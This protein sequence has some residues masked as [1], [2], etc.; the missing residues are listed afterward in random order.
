MSSTWSRRRWTFEWLTRFSPMRT[1]TVNS[2][3][4]SGQNYVYNVEIT[5]CTIG[6]TVAGTTVRTCHAAV[7]R[8]ACRVADTIT[9]HYNKYVSETRV[10]DNLNANQTYCRVV[11]V[12][13]V[14]QSYGSS[15]QATT[16]MGAQER[17]EPKKA[18]KNTK[19]SCRLMKVSA[20]L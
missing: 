8:L 17:C 12:S 7:L 6:S 13:H 14:T 2:T 18:T 16:N 20:K 10:A 9:N 15:T 19:G 11:E 4:H 3:T 1:S 5:T